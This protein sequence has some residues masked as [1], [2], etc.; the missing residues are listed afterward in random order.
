MDVLL[1]IDIFVDILRQSQRTGPTGSPIVIETEFEWVLCGCS[2]S[3]GDVNLHVTSHRASDPPTLTLEKRFIL[4]HFEMNHSHTKAGRFV[5]P[6]PR[7]PN[8]EPIGESRSLAV[9]RFLTLGRYLHHKDNFREVDSVI[10]EY[11]TLGHA[12]AVPIEDTDKDPSSVFYLP[13]HV[14]YISSSSTTKVR[15]VFNVSAKS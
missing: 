14:V 3:S 10:Q 7:K 4:Q 9:R 13:M 5:V 2:T 8:A 11:F 1:G 12:E 6:L 15:V